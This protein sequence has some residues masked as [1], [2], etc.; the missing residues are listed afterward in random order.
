[1][2]FIINFRNGLARA[3]HKTP[4]PLRW[5][6]WV[7]LL[8]YW[9]SPIDLIPDRLG[10]IGRLD[11]LAFSLM[12]FWA[13]DYAQTLDSLMAQSKRNGRKS[14]EDPAP[15]Q[16]ESDDPFVILGISRNAG[17]EEI[18][19]AYKKQMGTYHPD[20]FSHLGKEFEEIARRRTQDII[21][22]YRQLQS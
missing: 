13:F 2:S 21:K 22:A 20:K 19:A 7:L 18:K 3:I 10:L 12:M 8:A 1:M 9:I 5:L 17:P 14:Q 16:P 4:R 15:G 11:D 6:W